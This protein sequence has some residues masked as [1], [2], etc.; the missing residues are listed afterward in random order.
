M[1]FLLELPCSPEARGKF[2]FRGDVGDDGGGL[3]CP[4]NALGRLPAVAAQD[5]AGTLD[6][7]R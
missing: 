4:V 5:A 7:P 2:G 3:V 1:G 6:T